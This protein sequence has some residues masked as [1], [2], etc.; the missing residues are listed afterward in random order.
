M[1][2]LIIR[3]SV[4]ICAGFLLVAHFQS[5]E[6]T[7]QRYNP[8]LERQLIREASSYEGRGDLAEAERVLRIVLSSN[9]T[10]DVGLL[11]AERIFREQGTLEEILPL[12][13]NYLEINS[14]GA[15]ARSLALKVYQELGDLDNLKKSAEDWLIVDGNKPEPY[16]KIS[17]IFLEIYGEEEALEI[18]K[19][20][21][22]SLKEPSQFTLRIGDLLMEMGRYDSAAIAWAKGI[23]DDGSQTSAVIR[24]VVAIGE[25]GQNSIELLLEELVKEPTTTPR[26]RAATRIALEAGSVD[27]AL[28]FAEMALR[29]LEAQTRRGFLTVLAR[30]AEEVEDGAKASLW[31]YE[32]MR[33][34]A[35]DATE[36][37]ALNYRIVSAALE[38]GDT[39]TALTAQYAIANALPKGNSERRR[40]LAEG[41]RMG[42]MNGTTERL[43]ELREFKREFPDAVEVDELSVLL[44]ITLDL[45]GEEA[46][47]KSLLEGVE[48]PRSDLERGYLHL[49][50]D[51]IAMAEASLMA[52]L[53]GL[54]P[55]QA[56]EVLTLLEIMDRLQGADLEIVV[57]AAVLKHR[58][59]SKQA[60]SVL[61]LGLMD[62]GE[63][64]EP[65]LLSFAAYIAQEAGMNDR[66]AEFREDIVKDHS[67]SYEFPVAALELARYKATS[68]NGRMEAMTILENLIISRPN[69]ALTPLARRELQRLG[70]M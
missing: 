26:V 2:Q 28:D 57:K 56:T 48:G 47:A 7:A 21:E 53:S 25:E 66:A 33:D 60:L 6:I 68:E 30:E 49:V 31:A 65:V 4:H 67:E 11:A 40:A 29:D 1:N 23:G 51:E 16:R 18:L 12:V 55:H 9:P 37:K 50:N 39:L 19:R 22:R 62:V 59:Y 32:A 38:S 43:D 13:D 70:R 20:G 24:R 34:Q 36:I 14:G 69:S 8:S 64:G 41:F 10:S 17:E 35:L 44:A 5:T 52:A 61:E 3:I 15:V 46:M 42:P 45:E 27:K 54:P 58:G 63:F